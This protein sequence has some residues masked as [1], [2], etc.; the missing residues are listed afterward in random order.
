VTIDVS[1]I[2]MEQAKA[3]LA[4]E[5]KKTDKEID[6]LIKIELKSDKVAKN[7][8]ANVTKLLGNVVIDSGGFTLNENAR[9]SLI[10]ETALAYVK[11]Y[12]DESVLGGSGGKT[13]SKPG[14]ARRAAVKDKDEKGPAAL[15]LK[16]IRDYIAWKLG[17]EKTLDYRKPQDHD[18]RQ[19]DQEYRAQHYKEWL[20]EIRMARKEGK[21]SK[22]DV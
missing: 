6:K 3:A 21:Y 7:V 8:A 10:Y 9:T 19:V 4:G 16:K 12:I 2:L 15:T 13:Q 18:V 17:I 5:L 14:R 1:G 20:K 11:T 22:A